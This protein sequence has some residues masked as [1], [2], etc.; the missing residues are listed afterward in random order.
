MKSAKWLCTMLFLT[1]TASVSCPAQSVF[2]ATLLAPLSGGI[3]WF[4]GRAY[5]QVDATSGQYQIDFLD[6]TPPANLVAILGALG[7]T[8][9]IPLGT[10][11]PHVWSNNTGNMYP[12][13]FVPPPPPTIGSPL[14]TQGTQYNGTF[15]SS[16]ALYA[17]LTLGHGEI[18]LLGDATG[19]GGGTLQLVVVPEPGDVALLSCG[20]MLFLI[21]ALRNRYRQGAKGRA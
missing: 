9:T 7:E 3:N 20:L 10:G 6:T 8:M 18:H 12:D 21:P 2:Q 1:L 17:I 19:F 4:Y 5:F 15:Q 11:V 14:D 13:P 16:P